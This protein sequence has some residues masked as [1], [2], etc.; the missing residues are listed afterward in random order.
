MF[1]KYI[2]ARYRVGVMAGV[3]FNF[4]LAVPIATQ[5]NVFKVLQCTLS[6][7]GNGWCKFTFK[8]AAPNGTQTNVFKV[9]KCMLSGRSDGWGK[10]YF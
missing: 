5:T 6:G 7:R 2:N 3:S 4:K 9:N 1:S 10:F 8:L